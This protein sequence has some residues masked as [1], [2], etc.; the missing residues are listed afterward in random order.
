MGKNKQKIVLPPEL[1]PEVPDEEVEISDDDVQFV[2]EN[3]EYASL[4]K[5]LDTKSIDKYANFSLY[6]LFSL[7]VLKFVL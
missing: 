7:N 2:T 1:P 5:N 3:R 6:R 4:L